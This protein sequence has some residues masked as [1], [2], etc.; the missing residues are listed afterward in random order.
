VGIITPSAL[1]YEVHR[2]GVADID[3]G[4]HRLLIHGMVD[5]PVMLTME[6]IQALPSISRILFLECQG[7]TQLEWRRRN[8]GSSRGTLR[9]D[10]PERRKV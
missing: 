3:P 10:V 7:N 5:R 2:S 8:F 9:G 6:E 1:H 4:K